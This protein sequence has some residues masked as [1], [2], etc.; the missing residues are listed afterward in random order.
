VSE[1]SDTAIV[2]LL[3]ADYVAIDAAGKL[4]VIGGSLSVLGQQDQGSGAPSGFT[5]PFGLVVSVAVQS[6]L[7]GSECA[8]EVA[9]ED[10]KGEVVKLPGP[11]GQPQKMRIAQNS[12][13]EEP[14]LPAVAGV[15][16]GSLRARTNF[17]LM[18]NNGLPLAIGQLYLW[19]VRID[20]D[21][22]DDWTEEFFVPGPPPEPVIG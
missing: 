20:H 3:I 21:T 17:V 6:T 11:A 22:R 15:P 8:L 10:S 9:L 5:V 16:R 14:R 12:V 19:R 1:V 18:F 4:N 7:Y 13:F 2:R